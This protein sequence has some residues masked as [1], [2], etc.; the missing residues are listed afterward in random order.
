MGFGATVRYF[1][2]ISEYYFFIRYMHM[3][4]FTAVTRHGVRTDL[5][6]T[7]TLNIREHFGYM[8]NTGDST[9]RHLHLDVHR[10]RDGERLSPSLATQ[11]DPR[12]F[13]VPDFVARWRYLNIQP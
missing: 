7:M 8:G 4:D 5:N 11:I 13:F 1:D 10:Q 9:G 12:A 3:E 6:T 2:P